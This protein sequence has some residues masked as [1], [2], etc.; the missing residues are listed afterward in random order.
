M[1]AKIFRVFFI[2]VTLIYVFVVSIHT[3]FHKSFINEF[4]S[5]K[6][7]LAHFYAFPVLFGTIIFLFSSLILIALL[8]VRKKINI[9]KAYISC[10]GVIIIF[11]LLFVFLSTDKR[12]AVEEVGC[13]SSFKIVEWNALNSLDEESAKE[14]FANYDADI[15]VLPEFGGYIKG[16]KVNKRLRDL[17]SNVNIDYDR[18]YVY[19]SAETMGSIAPVTIVV[20]KDFYNYNIDANKAMTTFGTV[21]LN[22]S[23]KNIP[24]IVGLHTAPPLPGLMSYWERDLEL[25]AEDI[26][27]TYP[28]ALIVGDFNATLRHGKMNSITSHEDVLNYTSRFSR[29][30]WNNKLPAV[31]RTPIDHIL[32]PKGKY[33]VKNVE[34]RKLGVSDHIAVFAEICLK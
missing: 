29:G 34:L 21:Y 14:I 22:S 27:N 23:D 32:I 25:I 12:I 13:E 20:K 18:Y 6:I 16:E 33:I 30:T 2:I 4:L 15:V 10:F 28:N 1:R 7:L 26:I 24:S 9:D 5:T 19:Q 17:F 31:F 8:V 3:F 11:S